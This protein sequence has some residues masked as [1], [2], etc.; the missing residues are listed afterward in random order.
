MKKHDQSKLQKIAFNLLACLKFQRLLML[1]ILGEHD[2][3]LAKNGP[4]SVPESLLV[5]TIRTIR[6]KQVGREG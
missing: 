3:N 5:E 6:Q 4:V 1:I 2:R